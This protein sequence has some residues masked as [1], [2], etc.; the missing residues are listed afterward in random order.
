M[1]LLGG[2]IGAGAN[3]IGGLLG[4]SEA[5][6]QMDFQKRA[7]KNRIQWTVADANKAG[8]S[9]IYALGAPTFNPSPVMS[10]MPEAM[11]NAGQDIA[12]AVDATQDANEKATAYTKSIQ[13]LNI[14]RMGL[15]NELLG[16]QISKI[17]QPGSPPAAPGGSALIPG[18]GSGTVGKV[19]I[20]P[21]VGPMV[22]RVPGRNGGPMDF[23]TGPT[24][25]SQTIAD[26]Y[27]DAAQ[28]VYGMYRLANDALANWD[29]TGHWSSPAAINAFMESQIAKLLASRSS[30]AIS[31]RRRY[32]SGW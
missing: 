31:R 1:S 28:E 20:D 5:D 11:A 19:K 3:I 24:S 21:D 9:P 2:I 30:G 10:G 13:A 6:A 25:N 17:R 32:S 23:V 4:K 15:E 16:A 27:G 14:Q 29:R 8:V 12:R 26:Q 18:Q 22:L 7:M